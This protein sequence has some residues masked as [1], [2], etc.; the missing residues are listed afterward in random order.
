MEWCQSP[1]LCISA[2][3]E[4][5][6]YLTM[7]ELLKV[8]VACNTHGEKMAGK[9]ENVVTHAALSRHEEK[10]SFA[11]HAP[12]YAVQLY[13]TYERHSP[14]IDASQP[15]ALHAPET[16]LQLL[17]NL[18]LFCALLQIKQST[19]AAVNLTVQTSSPSNSRCRPAF[20]SS[21]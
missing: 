20:G 11:K 15:S 13:S 7:Q 9:E 18:R 10:S 1:S 21:E 5:T 2:V 17:P 3:H 4:A 16:L 8:Q 12:L 6:V 19:V 14:P